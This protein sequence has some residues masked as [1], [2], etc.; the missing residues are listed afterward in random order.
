MQ[1]VSAD[2]SRENKL[3]ASSVLLPLR[4]VLFFTPVG[5]LMSYGD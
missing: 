3:K 4:H 1:D 2:L 5:S